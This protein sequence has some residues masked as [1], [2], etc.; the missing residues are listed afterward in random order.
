MGI[1]GWREERGFQK[2]ERKLSLLKE[3][4]FGIALEPGGYF[5]ESGRFKEGSP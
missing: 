1:L 3:C 4:N 2:R 5:M